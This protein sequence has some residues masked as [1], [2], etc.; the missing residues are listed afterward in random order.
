MKVLTKAKFIKFC[1]EYGLVV[2][3]VPL[4]KGTSSAMD[5]D[6]DLDRSM[7]L[8]HLEEA[9]KLS[10]FDDFLYT[11]RIAHTKNYVDPWRTGDEC[12]EYTFPLVSVHFNKCKYAGSICCT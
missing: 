5:C 12:I 10:L 2:N 11:H 7:V 4:E 8:L 1:K 6:A 9:E 3:P